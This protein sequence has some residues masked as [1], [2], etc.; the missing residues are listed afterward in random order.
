VPT[1]I[2]AFA[3]TKLIFEVAINDANL[4]TDPDTFLATFQSKINAAVAA[5][6]GLANN[7]IAVMTGLCI[8]E[9]SQAGGSPWGAN[10]KDS[11]VDAINTRLVT[12]AANN[13]GVVTVLDTRTPLGVWLQ[14]HVGVPGVAA[15]NVTFDQFHPTTTLGAKLM[16][17]FAMANIVVVA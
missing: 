16:G 10:P 7:G 6:P 9:L 12:L 5:T 2:T 17:Q 1:R 11:A 3:P 15:G 14:T 13:P 8:G 4:G